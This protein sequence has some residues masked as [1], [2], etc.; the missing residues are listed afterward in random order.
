MS[1]TAIMVTQWPAV[2]LGVGTR[3]GVRAGVAVAVGQP[4]DAVACQSARVCSPFLRLRG[5]THVHGRCV[6]HVD[7]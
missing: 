4:A 5:G 7:T 3:V 1:N 2:A 6:F